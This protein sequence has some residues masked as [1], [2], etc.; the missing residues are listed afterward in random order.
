MPLNTTINRIGR[1]IRAAVVGGGDGALIGSTHRTA[2]RFD[3]HFE[4]VAGVL[5]RNPEQSM[6]QGVALGLQRPYG[7]LDELI[8]QESERNDGADVIVVMTPND[9]H[10]VY[11]R[12]ALRA[13]FHVICDKP[14]ANTLADARVLSEVSRKQ[15]RNLF[16][17][18]NTTGYPMVR[19]ARAMIDQGMLGTPHLVEV[20]YAQ[21]NFGSLVEQS[22]LQLDRQTA[23]RIDPEC[24]GEHHLLLDVG[25][26]VQNLAS[27][28]LARD[29][30]RVFADV[31]PAVAG[32][33]FADSASI[34][35]RLEGDVRATLTMTKAATGAPQLFGIAVYGDKGGLRWEQTQANEL[36]YSRQGHPIATYT[37]SV[38]ELTPLARRSM[39][40]PYAHPEG[41]REGFA[42]LYADFAEQ[43]TASIDG[44]RADPL[45]MTCPSID[46]GVRSLA[47]VEACVDANTR[48]AWVDVE[49][50]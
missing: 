42:S 9:S 12:D 2:L 25:V 3:D 41:Y 17:T 39:H 4:I 49:T 13:G 21:G 46:D 22:A 7:T 32:R 1:R 14:V 50:A 47:F 11:C 24:G 10:F 29:F 36:L 15:G 48:Q 23:W 26:H 44:R 38:A 35:G 30:I 33:T 19:Q 37:R 5:S 27:Y 40:A 6:Q 34:L 45:A 31:G 18:Y 8:T 16:V 20:R 43:I 28:V